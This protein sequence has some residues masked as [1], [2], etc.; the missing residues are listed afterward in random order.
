MDLEWIL[1][2]PKK[3]LEK[4]LYMGHTIVKT[5]EI[6][7]NRI[8]LDT[9]AFYTWTLTCLVLGARNAICYKLVFSPGLAWLNP[10]VDDQ[11]HANTIGIVIIFN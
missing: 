8:A 6:H 2:I 7:L 5:P 9:G 10:I 4:L 11:A 1:K 3:I